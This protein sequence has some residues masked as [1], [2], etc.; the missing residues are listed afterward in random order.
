MS[1]PQPQQ[2][3]PPQGTPPQ[4]S[5]GPQSQIICTGCRTLL[6]YPQGASNVR[7]ALCNQITSVP[8]AGTEMAQ[9]VCGGCRCTDPAQVPAPCPPPPCARRG[10]PDQRE[11][12]VLALGAC[13]RPSGL[14]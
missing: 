6:V 13:R 3:Q 4:T 5:G 11:R 8:P 7:C 2:Q 10:A 12:L 1:A 14:C 9:L